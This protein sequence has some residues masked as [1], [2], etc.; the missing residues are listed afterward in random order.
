MFRL[1]V[2]RIGIGLFF[3]VLV[4]DA[5]SQA[6]GE[7]VIVFTNKPHIDNCDPSSF[8]SQRALERRQRY[9]IPLKEEDFPI[10]DFYSDSIMRLDSSMRLVSKSKWMNYIVVSCDTTLLE[11]ILRFSFVK[12][13]SSLHTVHYAELLPEIHFTEIVP[14]PVVTALAKNNDQWIDTAHYGMM[15]SQIKLHNGHLLHHAGYRGEGMLI[16]LLDGGFYGVNTLPAFDDMINDN[17]LVYHYDFVQEGIDMFSSVNHGMCVLS[18]MASSIDGIAVGTAPEASYVLLKTEAAS[19]ENIREEYF[20]VAG[21]ECADSMG[22]DVANISLGYTAFDDKNTSHTFSSLDGMHSVAS[23]AVSLAIEKG[24]VVSV[25]AGNSGGSTWKY[26]AVPS[27]AYNALSVAAVDVQGE[28]ADFSSRGSSA[29]DRIKPNVASVGWKTFAQY[30]DGSIGEENGTSL[31]APVNAGL[32]ACLRQAFPLKTSQEI[33]RAILQ[34]CSHV[35][36]P[37]TLTGYGIPNYWTAY[38]MLEAS[39]LVKKDLHIVYPNP[40]QTT[41]MVKAY[42]P[43]RL[44]RVEVMDVVGRPLLSVSC[45][46]SDCAY[47]DVSSLSSGIYILKIHT[48]ENIAIKKISKY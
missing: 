42:Y 15:Y 17:R 14:Y 16:A 27:D 21:L 3:S 43:N 45:D 39:N 10:D 30:N 37:D 40:V 48:D 13:V 23:I 33:I 7:Y 4:W 38:R 26:F 35:T 9:R 2:K 29:F 41:L 22:V 12:Q 28:V 31:A 6:S 24:M 36:F 5:F 18:T 11:D 8:L 46:G 19:Y 44:F 47:V 25:A 20:L 34:S 32:V 1:S